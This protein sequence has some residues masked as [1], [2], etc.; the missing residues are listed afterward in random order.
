MKRRRTALTVLG[1]LMLSSVA[2]AQNVPGYGSARASCESIW[3]ER[4][5]IFDRA[6]HCFSSTL[7]K[8]VFNNSNCR[9]RNPRLNQ[10]DQAWVDEIKRGERR[11]GCNVNTSRTGINVDTLNGTVRFG[12]GGVSY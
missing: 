12:R 4:N 2:Y 7:G 1:A 9:T 5:R 10:S 8:E 6:G 11:F 3:I